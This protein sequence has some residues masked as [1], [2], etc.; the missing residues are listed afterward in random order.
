MNWSFMRSWRALAA[1][2]LF[3]SILLAGLVGWRASRALRAAREAVRSEG[4]I[5]F[6]VQ[7]FPQ[8]HDQDFESIGTPAVFSQAARFLGDLYIA[9][10]VGLSQYSVSG[11]LLRNYAVGRELPSSPLLA[12]APAMLADSRA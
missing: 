8:S 6:T 4:E 3:I 7:P 10:P 1:V 5:S 9:G 11:T 2:V 12:I